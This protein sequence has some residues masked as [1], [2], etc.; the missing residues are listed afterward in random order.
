MVNDVDVLVLGGGISGLASAWWLGREGLHVEVWERD[1]HIGGKIQTRK[2]AGYTTERS[3]TLVLNFRHEVDALLRESGLD[4]A[5]LP[6]AAAGNRY[7]VQGG[8]MVAVPTRA[9]D[10]VR[11]E[12][13]SW[14]AKLRLLTAPLVPRKRRDAESVAEFISRRFGREMFDKAMEPY[15]AGVLA[16]DP[17]QAEARAVLPRLTALEDRYGSLA[18]GVFC[19]I[20]QRKATGRTTESF[21]FAGGMSTLVATLANR[22]GVRV[23]T[24]TSAVELVPASRGWRV[25]SADGRSVRAARVVL[26]TPAGDA[27]RLVRPLESETSRLL[28]GIRYAPLTVVHIGL[29]RNDVRH[30]LDGTGVLFPRSE[31]LSPLGCIWTS[32]L[33]PERAPE[34]SALLDC[35]LGGARQPEAAAWDD[36]RSVDHCLRAMDPLLG[37]DGTPEMARLDRHAHGLPLYHGRHVARIRAIK[38]GLAQRPGLHLAA[39]FAGGVSVRDRIVSGRAM[40]KEIIASLSATSARP[41]T[42]FGKRVSGLLT[43]VGADSAT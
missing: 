40:A 30:P 35:Y 42:V 12:L 5:K 23:L 14:N 24:G 21:S 10:L 16:C 7:V 25:L 1:E 20:L 43:A 41:Q 19:R 17:D 39:N 38:A 33:L 4:R 37:I 3:A 31:R 29:R 26:S 2:A 6:R 13:W 28:D 27:A 34:G 15:V 8:R 22:P 18:L 9:R 36:A 32:A 11:S